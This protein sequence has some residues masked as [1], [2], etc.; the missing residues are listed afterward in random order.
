MKRFTT[1]PDW[2]TVAES[3]VPGFEGSNWT[4]LVAPAGTPREI[5]AKINADAN[6]ALK[7][8][9][10]RERFVVAG[11]EAVGSTSEEAAAKM[12]DDSERYGKMIR[13]MKI[14]ID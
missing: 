3:G 9:D 2:P 6:R 1:A 11:S 8:A 10:T 13:E 12:R 7:A 4:A 14:S 5:V